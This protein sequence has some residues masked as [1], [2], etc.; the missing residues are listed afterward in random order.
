MPRQTH[1]THRTITLH[2]HPPAYLSPQIGMSSNKNAHMHLTSCIFKIARVGVL[3]VLFRRLCVHKIRVKRGIL[4]CTYH[5]LLPY[6]ASPS[7][8]ET[9]KNTLL[10]HF[11]MICWCFRNVRDSMRF[12]KKSVSLPHL[13]KHSPFTLQQQQ[14]QQQQ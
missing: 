6:V 2:T 1:N 7:L 11:Q 13:K 8:R 4:L 10:S 5:Q 12:L 14:Q 3:A 9:L